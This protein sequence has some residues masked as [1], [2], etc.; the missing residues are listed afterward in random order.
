MSLKDRSTFRQELGTRLDVRRFRL[1]IVDCPDPPPNDLK[2]GLSWESTLDC[3]ALGYDPANDFVLSEK[4]VSGFHCEI[5]I[6][7]RGARIRDLKSRNGTFVDGVSVESAF[8]RHGSTIRLGHVILRFE[9]LDQSNPLPISERTQ[10]GDMVSSSAAMRCCFAVME[11][12]AAY[13]ATILFEG[14]TGTGKT[15]AAEAIHR[16]SKR[17]N[18]M[19]LVVDCGALPPDL[20]DDELFGHKKNAFTGANDWRKGVFE[21]AEGGT[22]FLDEIGEL[23]L[24]LQAKLLRVIETREVRRLGV[25]TPIKVDV[26]IM[27]ATHRDLRSE[28]NANKFRTDLYYRLAVLRT[29]IP[30]LRER[31]EDIPQ[32]VDRLL[33]KLGATPQ[34]KANL[35]SPEFMSAL[36]R[37]AW[38]GNI[39][40]LRNY[41]ERCVVFD[42]VVP[43]DTQETSS[44]FS[45][46]ASQPYKGEKARAQDAFEREYLQKLLLLHGG[47]VTR[48]AAGAK[49][50]RVYLHKLLRK[51]RIHYE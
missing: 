38:P 12:A 47:N 46:D 34:F 21:E 51:H 29:R 6:E 1:V 48:A 39:R 23:P 32:L 30:P 15:T 13:D 10:F 8:L 19:F 36:Q 14:E 18:G 11:R 49:I 43:T 5:K 3:C 22:V 31:P 40:E 50:A 16:E 44:S 45:V 20:I 25:N 28:M 7:H 41:L 26:R 9:L 24:D 2:R 27:A 17:K 4:A 37:A 35:C 42:C 33:D